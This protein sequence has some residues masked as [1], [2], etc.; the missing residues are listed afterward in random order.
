MNAD[1]QKSH[2]AQQK[3]KSQ[4]GPLMLKRLI[5]NRGQNLMVTWVEYMVCNGVTGIKILLKK[6]WVLHIKAGQD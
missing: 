6:I 5:G 1:L 3:E 4:Y 2:T